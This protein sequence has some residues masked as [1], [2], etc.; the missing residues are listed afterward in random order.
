MAIM[1][2]GYM[3]KLQGYIAG[4]INLCTV[5]RE[6]TGPHFGDGRMHTTGSLGNLNPPAE[7][8]V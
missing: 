8:A 1:Q 3:A 7:V 6:L 2:S 4:Y 5:S